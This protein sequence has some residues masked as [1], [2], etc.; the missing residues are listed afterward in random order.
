MRPRP[1]HADTEAVQCSAVQRGTPANTQHTRAR[2]A[3]IGRVLALFDQYIGKGMKPSTRIKTTTATTTAL[4]SNH[5]D[6]LINYNYNN[7]K[8]H[9]KNN[10]NNNNSINKNKCHSITIIEQ[11]KSYSIQGRHC[12][13]IFGCIY[14]IPISRCVFHAIH[15]SVARSVHHA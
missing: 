6:N 11:I 3:I 10:N 12:Y 2:F 8:N 1:I 9:R 5:K 15:P 14:R 13:C 4:Y 7:R